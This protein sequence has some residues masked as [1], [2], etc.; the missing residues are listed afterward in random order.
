MFSAGLIKD[1]TN[2]ALGDQKRLD[3]LEDLQQNREFNKTSGD[4]FNW[5]KEIA[6]EMH[7]CPCDVQSFAAKSATRTAA[8]SAVTS[9]KSGAMSGGAD[10]LG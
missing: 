2:Q 1:F 10:R 4:L 8:L 7:A 9:A 5:Q 3:R 6:N